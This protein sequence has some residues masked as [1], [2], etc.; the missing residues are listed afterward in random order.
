MRAGSV[1]P[2]AAATIINCST[3]NYRLQP[4]FSNTGRTATLL[5]PTV[6]RHR[7]LP[8]FYLESNTV[9]HTHPPSSLPPPSFCANLLLLP[10]P[11]SSLLAPLRP[12]ITQEP[13]AELTRAPKLSRFL[14]YAVPSNQSTPR[15][16][17]RSAPG[18]AAFQS[19]QKR[20]SISKDESIGQSRG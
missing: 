11:L 4:S 2:R 17:D 12:Q 19:S 13:L 9:P 14:S 5:R 16:L 18:I 3:S 20:L 8:C 7:P 10:L 6:P 15:H 1:G